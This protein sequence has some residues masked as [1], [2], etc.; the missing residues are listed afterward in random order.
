MIKINLLSPLDKENLHW[1]KINN[2]AIKSI[3]YV[4]LAMTVFVGGFLFSVEYLKAE[5]NALS[6]QYDS[7]SNLPATK[8]MRDIEKDLKES[9][10]EISN[11]YAIQSGHAGWTMLFESV[12][13]LIPAGVRLKS[14]NA[15]YD[16]G[17]DKASAQ[18]SMNAESVPD[19][20]DKKIR[21]EITG[22]AKTRELLLALESKLKSSDIFFDFQYDTANYVKSVDIDFKYAFFVKEQN[23]LK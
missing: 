13:N 15:Q 23:L 4:M 9:K 6:V 11:I 21:V 20:A 22:N 17:A 16:T 12:S 7:L 10:S 8:E 2:M 1:E 18:A 3:I 14:I 19:A 5:K